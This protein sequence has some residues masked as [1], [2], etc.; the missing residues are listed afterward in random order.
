M[1]LSTR[2][3]C[4]RTAFTPLLLLF[5]LLVLQPCCISSSGDDS[6]LL[7]VLV[8]R[9]PE[10]TLGESYWSAKEAENLNEITAW[11]MDIYG[12]SYDEIYPEDLTAELL[13]DGNRLAYSVMVDN[14]NRLSYD[15]AA[16]VLEAVAQKGMGLVTHTASASYVSQS[17]GLMEVP[18]K[19]WKDCAVVGEFS[20]EDDLHYITRLFYQPIEHMT[21]NLVRLEHADYSYVH[22]VEV[23]DPSRGHVLA[24]VLESHMSKPYEPEIVASAVGAGRIV[25]FAR[26]Y[27]VYT[28]ASYF[29]GERDHTMLFLPGRAIEWA[30]RD[31]VLASKWL[32][33]HGHWCAHAIVMDG[34]YDYPPP[35]YSEEWRPP[36]TMDELIWNYQA[37]ENY[38]ATLG[39]TFTACITFRNNATNGWDA[40][41]DLT[42]WDAGI[43]A[44]GWLG[45]QGNELALGA[46]DYLN[47]EDMTR[48]ANPRA[49]ALQNLRRGREA[50]E[51][52]LGV[53]DP[54]YVFFYIPENILTGGEMYNLAADAGFK[55]ICGGIYKVDF[56][57]DF[58][59]S[60]YP[61]YLMSREEGFDPRA[62]IVENNF[63]FD[64]LTEDTDLFYIDTVYD[65]H[66]ALV[67]RI[68]LWQVHDNED[69]LAKL[70]NHIRDTRE[71]NVWW[72]TLGELGEY[73]LQR[74]DVAVDSTARDCGRRILT[75][76]TNRGEDGIEGFC[77]KF[78]LEDG[79]ETAGQSSMP[80]EVTSV[81][82]DGVGL[83]EG[84]SWTLEDFGGGPA[85]L[86]VWMDMPP[87][88]STIVE[89]TATGGREP[90]PES[91]ILSLLTVIGLGICLRQVT[92]RSC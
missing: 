2:G 32:Y 80:M 59:G 88:E 84:E 49:R 14:G 81:L 31:G 41:Y 12:F 69:I 36:S 45:N 53:D 17:M 62:V 5:T 76:V 78:K 25:W 52:V 6:C 38:L 20:I 3:D 55:V 91:V 28:H 15:K 92:T 39:Q 4:L 8:L 9:V 30:S 10:S 21:H 70:G 89:V 51:N 43:N 86:F 63:F 57:Y 71:E 61:Y 54:A 24:R 83:V 56:P 50:M 18:G 27:Q 44:I 67:L 1:D 13:Y 65:N 47:Y 40:G 35:G 90:I 48:S 75:N 34:Y 64:H 66:G 73:T 74:Y 60:I 68:P 87:G 16:I 33:P 79:S 37:V 11:L 19:G 22:R 77:L 42:R 72:T 26:P 23:L 85:S 82:R 7:R 29:F 46:L 58:Y